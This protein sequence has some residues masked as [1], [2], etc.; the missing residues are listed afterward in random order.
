MVVLRHLVPNRVVN[1][2]IDGKRV[3]TIGPDKGDQTDPFHNFV[4]FSAPLVMGQFDVF[5]MGFVDNCIVKD[6]PPASLFYVTFNLIPQHL[7]SQ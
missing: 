2:I 6:K 3:D 1:P 4:M 7:R 5:L